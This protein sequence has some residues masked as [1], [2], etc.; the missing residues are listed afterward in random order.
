MDAMGLAVPWNSELTRVYT[1]ADAINLRKA[2]QNTN[3][4][5]K[6]RLDQAIIT[7]TYGT[8]R[9]CILP[10]LY[11]D[12]VPKYITR[13]EAGWAVNYIRVRCCPNAPEW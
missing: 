5:Q 8:A 3:P 2:L 13:W 7:W 1:R 9:I 4:W 11:N 12:P 6:V 10:D